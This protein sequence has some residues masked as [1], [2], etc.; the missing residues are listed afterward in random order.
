MFVITTMGKFF[1][2]WPTIPTFRNEG[3]I[4][5]HQTSRLQLGRRH[6]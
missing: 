4:H 5:G 6:H 2:S 1:L 3:P